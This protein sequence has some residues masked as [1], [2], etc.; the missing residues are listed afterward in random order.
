MRQGLLVLGL[1]AMLSVSLAAGC[2]A[3][4]QSKPQ[5]TKTPTVATQLAKLLK[6]NKSLQKQLAKSKVEN[7][8]LRTALN[9]KQRAGSGNVHHSGTVKHVHSGNVRFELVLPTGA[10]PTFPV[11]PA[12]TGK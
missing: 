7:R 1:V 6:Q 8:R 5:P 3:F 9:A 4:G 2:G 12:P 10:S 11:I